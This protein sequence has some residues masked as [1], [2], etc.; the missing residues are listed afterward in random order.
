MPWREVVPVAVRLAVVSPPKKVT[1]VVVYDPRLVTSWRVSVWL[2]DWQLVPSAKH[3][4]LELTVKKVKMPSE[5]ET[6]PAPKARE[7]LKV[8]VPEEVSV[9]VPPK[10]SVPLA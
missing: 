1:E 7:P 3:T 9:R 10:T 2:V 8:L 4:C 6:L 5:D